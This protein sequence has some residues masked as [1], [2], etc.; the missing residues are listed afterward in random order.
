MNSENH[1]KIIGFI[2]KN[3]TASGRQL[4]KVLGRDSRSTWNIL[5]HLLRR[6]IIAHCGTGGRRELKLAPNWEGKV[7]HRKT[8]PR[9]K[10]VSP[11]IT[12]VCRQNW[13]GYK[14]H[15]IFGSAKS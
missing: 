4:A 8:A 3:K 2:L 15:Q 6:E 5:M 9:R 12:E 14:I 1:Q 10:A 13:Q 7:C 11:A